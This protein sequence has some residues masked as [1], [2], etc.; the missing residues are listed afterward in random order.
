MYHYLER[1][2]TVFYELI[3]EN[4]LPRSN[5]KSNGDKMALF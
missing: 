3:T 4:V 2:N 5:R 1:F